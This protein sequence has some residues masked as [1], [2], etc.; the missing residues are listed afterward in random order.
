MV[1]ISRAIELNEVGWWSKW[2]SVRWLRKDLFILNSQDTS[3]PFFNRAGLVSC[4]ASE[5]DFL[6]IEEAFA[7]NG[8]IPHVVLPEACARSWSALRKAGYTDVD[9]MVVWVAGDDHIHPSEEVVV[10]KA[11][12]READAW[13]DAYLLSFYGDLSQRKTVLRVV[14]RLSRLA[15]VSLLVAESK[16]KVLGVTALFRS[17]KLLGL[18]CLGTLPTHRGRGIARSILAA[19]RVMAAEEGRKLVLQS[20]LSE[21]THPFYSRFGFQKLYVKRLLQKIAIAHVPARGERKASIPDVL[22]RRDPG[23]GPHLFAAVFQGFERVRAVRAVFGDQTERVL[24]ELT[25][26]IVDEKGYMHIDA[27]KGSIVVSAGYLKEGDESY[28]YLDAVHELVHIRQH[29]EGRELWDR[30]YK[31]VDRPTELEAYGV[32]VAEARRIG[33]GVKRLTDYLKVE[34]VS[35]DDFARFLVTLG[36]TKPGR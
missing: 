15:R 3:E 35:E 22:I 29:M 31:Y 7:K 32:A 23:V 25:L 2:G 12:P 30:S 33:F 6:E 1:Q 10:R 14:K 9:R 27:A 17:S 24:S 11:E 16:G 4:G 21:E 34:W 36:V 28:L 5:R 19:S 26:D 20:L 18:Y 13:C 8:R